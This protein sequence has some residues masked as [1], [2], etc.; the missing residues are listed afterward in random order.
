MTTEYSHRLRL[1]HIELA[2]ELFVDGAVTTVT[3]GDGTIVG[4]V[5]RRLEAAPAGAEPGDSWTIVA[6]GGEIDGDIAPLIQLALSQALAGRTPV[7]CDLSDVT[8]FGAAG[9]N[10]LLAA[11]RRAAELGCAFYLRGVHGITDRVLTVVDPDG[12][13]A[14]SG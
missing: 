13:V 11:H 1:G 4:T 3:D 7:C 12:I 9:A 14:R 6:V 2:D 10:T 5:V 8:F